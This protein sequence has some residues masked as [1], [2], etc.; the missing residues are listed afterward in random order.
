MDFNLQVFNHVR[1]KTGRRS[2]MTWQIL[3]LVRISLITYLVFTLAS[4]E[5][6]RA[7]SIVQPSEMREALKKATE[8]R[9]KNLDQVRS[10]FESEPVRKVLSS[11]RRLISTQGKFRKPLRLCPPMNSQ[12]CRHARSGFNTTSRPVR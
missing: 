6:V 11:S 4:S 2:G 7:Q 8:T 1:F 10:F 3:K 5:A 12:N 9:Q